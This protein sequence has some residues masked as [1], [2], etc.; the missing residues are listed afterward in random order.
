MRLGVFGSS[1]MLPEN[2]VGES[3]HAC[4]V[5][6]DAPWST[7]RSTALALCG[8]QQFS[9]LSMPVAYSVVGMTGSM[10]TDPASILSVAM[11]NESLTANE[12]PPFVLTCNPV[13]VA[14]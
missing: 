14:A 3:A 9:Q 7:D 1:T 12:V 6:Q 5:S 4:R 10:T 2:Q 13:W 8:A 11:A